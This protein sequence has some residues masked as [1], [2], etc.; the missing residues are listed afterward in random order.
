MLDVKQLRLP[1]DL[2]I[3]VL[4]GIGDKNELFDIDKVK[5]FY[6]A[7]PDNKK[8]F[9]VMENTTHARISVESWE[10]IVVWLN[11]TL[12]SEQKSNQKPYFT[13]TH[14]L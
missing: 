4:V 6:N 1:K 5:E 7:V 8:E 11:K 3:P 2:N 10:K 14:V 12:V 9:L 13:T